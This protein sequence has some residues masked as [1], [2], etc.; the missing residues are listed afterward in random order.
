LDNTVLITDEVTLY[1]KVSRNG[2]K[3]QDKV[4]G[5]KETEVNYYYR[6]SVTQKGRHVN[7][8]CYL[9]HSFRVSD[10]WHVAFAGHSI[11]TYQT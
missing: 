1:G 5:K 2:L 9:G 11:I 7:C 8:K 10:K 4:G 6:F 3:T